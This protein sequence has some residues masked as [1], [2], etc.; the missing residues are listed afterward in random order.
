MCLY[1]ER[2]LEIYHTGKSSLCSE[3]REAPITAE[4]ALEIR[5]KIVGIAE[6]L[7]KEKYG[8]QK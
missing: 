3:L 8:E 5:R 2:I 6:Q 1:A 4:N 7:W